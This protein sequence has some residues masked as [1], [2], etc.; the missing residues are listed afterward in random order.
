LAK[1][2]G[3]NAGK[4]ESPLS[5]V[6]KVLLWTGVAV[7]GLS[8]FVVV[9]VAG[10]E[11][12]MAAFSGV[13]GV[14]AFFCVFFTLVH[15]L[16]RNRRWQITIS[17]SAGFRN[18][19]WAQG[20]GFIFTMYLPFRLGDPVRVLALEEL[21]KTGVWSLAASVVME[22]IIDVVV[23]LILFL[24]LLPFLNIAPEIKNAAAVLGV[25]AAGTMAA[26]VAAAAFGKMVL[27]GRF[28]ALVAPLVEQTREAL[29]HVLRLHVVQ[30]VVWWT[31]AGWVTSVFRHW[32]ALSAFVPD[33]T[34]IESLILTVMLSLA[35]AVPSAPGFIGLFQLV[36]Q[37][38]LV[39]PFAAKYDA[40]TALGV[41]VVLHLSLYLVTTVFGVAGLAIIGQRLARH[42]V[43]TLFW[44]RAR[45]F[46]LARRLGP[47]RE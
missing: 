45:K 14:Y 36:G 22:R 38:A 21:E 6:K 26:L 41:T 40:A 19:L 24:A 35:T 10:V 25:G 20:V 44:E 8:L 1:H 42:S 2:L 9:K 23:A 39:I 27:A 4:T 3:A 34:L 7:S 11:E 16:V 33:A 28:R 13:D 37:Q 47:E 32:L 18:C 31:L 46:A 5:A 30:G 17:R 15:I 43:I 29:A 12:F